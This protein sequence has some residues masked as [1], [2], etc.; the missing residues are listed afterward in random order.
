MRVLSLDAVERMRA[1]VFVDRPGKGIPM[2]AARSDG[3]PSPAVAVEPAPA[4]DLVRLTLRDI[5]LFGVISNRGMVVVAALMGLIWQFDAAERF[6]EL[7]KVLKVDRLKELSDGTSLLSGVL[8]GIAGL[9]ALV[10]L[11]RILSSA[12]ATTCVWCRGS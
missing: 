9:V 4:R 6:G 11:M 3:E 12:G 2:E 10:V 8:L 7:S 1:L 5:V